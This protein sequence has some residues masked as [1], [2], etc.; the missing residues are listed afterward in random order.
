LAIR[1]PILEVLTEAAFDQLTMGIALSTW[2][3]M[4]E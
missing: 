4:N 3:L 2:R 1:L